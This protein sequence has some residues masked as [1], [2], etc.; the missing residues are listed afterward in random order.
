MEMEKDNVQLSGRA[1]R[2]LM[3]NDSEEKG[4]D[5]ESSD[6]WTPNRDVNPQW[7]CGS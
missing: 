2:N 7:R 3:E 4:L 1:M 5:Y 6:W